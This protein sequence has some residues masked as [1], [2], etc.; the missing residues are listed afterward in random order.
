MTMKNA[1]L[2][3]C[4]TLAS[5]C[6]I[7][8]PGYRNSRM[9]GR[10][11]GTPAGNAAVDPDK[12]CKEGTME[13]M[14]RT[15][16]VVNTDMLVAWLTRPHGPYA[17]VLD[18]SSAWNTFGGRTFPILNEVCDPQVSGES[19]S[20]SCTDEHG[21]ESFKTYVSIDLGGS[22]GFGGQPVVVLADLGGGTYQPF[23]HP[24][25]EGETVLP[26]G[27][28]CYIQLG[29]AKNFAPTVRLYKNYGNER[30][31]VLYDE[32]DSS[33]RECWPLDSR[34]HGFPTSDNTYHIDASRRTSDNCRGH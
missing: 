27:S 5:A 13:E 2:I 9:N 17:C 12:L 10:P 25:V 30:N 4:L 6:T 14:S 1:T 15:K 20:G 22:A 34:S 31:V 21:D 7:S 16:C 11:P 28:A 33:Y 26:P 24:T 8:G 3:L 32:P 29:R 23:F 19:I 18:Q